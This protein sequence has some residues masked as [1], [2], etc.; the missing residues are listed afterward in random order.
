M[1]YVAKGTESVT[2]EDLDYA[3]SIYKQWTG[4]SNQKVIFC[5]V[6]KVTDTE[7]TRKE[8]HYE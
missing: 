7:Y 1:Y 6:I 8:K 5:K 4:H 3:E 2:T